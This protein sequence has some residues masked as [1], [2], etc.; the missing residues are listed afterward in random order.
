MKTPDRL[1]T[2]DEMAYFLNVDTD[3]VHKYEKEGII[4]RVPGLKSPRYS[5]K[6]I[7]TMAGIDLEDFSPFLLRKAQKETEELRHQVET[8]QGK[9]EQI[10]KLI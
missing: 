8:L 5:P 6:I 2:R 9:L 1:L 3:T 10:K 4:H 7:A